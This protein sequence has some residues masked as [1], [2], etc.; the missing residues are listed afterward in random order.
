MGRFYDGGW[1]NWEIGKVRYGI[2]TKI[3]GGVGE[4]AEML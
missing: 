3:A 4:E 1:D 2:K